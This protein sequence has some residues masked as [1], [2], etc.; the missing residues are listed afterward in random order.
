MNEACQLQEE[1]L[2]KRKEIQGD[3]HPNTLTS[4]DNLASSYVQQGRPKEACELEEEVLRKRKEI[5]GDTHPDTLTSMNN[6]ALTYL[7]QGR[8]N[9]ACELRRCYTML[10]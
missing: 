6:L 1:V 3:G 8:T 4:M 7:Q 2:R 9:E 10:E 5:L